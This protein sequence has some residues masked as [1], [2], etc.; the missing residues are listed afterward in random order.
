LDQ[1]FYRDAHLFVHL[2]HQVVMLDGKTITLTGLQYRVLVLLVENAGEVVPR[3]AF[4][5]QIWG[6]MPELSPKQVD[7]HIQALRRI[8]GAYADRYIET[9]HGVGYRFWPALPRR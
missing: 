2:R 1:P 5:R 7:V 9:V 8:L 4:L 3:G 6:H